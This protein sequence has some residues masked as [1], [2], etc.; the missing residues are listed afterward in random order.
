MESLLTALL[1][2]FR[3]LDNSVRATRLVESRSEAERNSGDT[4]EWR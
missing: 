3:D 2:P 1:V 4:L